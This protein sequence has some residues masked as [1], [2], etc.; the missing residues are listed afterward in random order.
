MW[1]STAA[2]IQ[3]GSTSSTNDPSREQNFQ[4][5]EEDEEEE[6]EELL[7]ESSGRY[8]GEYYESDTSND[9]GTESLTWISWFCSLSGHEYFAEVAED[10][11]E[12]DFNLTGLN[13]T[14][15]FYKEA[16]EMIL[17]VEPEEES[18][19]VPDVSL[20]ENS[21][22]VLYGMIHQR[23]ILTRQ[24]LQQ[25]VDKYENNHFGHCPRVYC[26]PTAVV[27]CGRNDHPGLETVKLFCP[28]CLDLYTPPSSRYHNIDG[29]YFG[30]TFPHL[31]FQQFPELLPNTP[32][33]IY[34]PKI[35]GFKV[36]ERSRSGPRMQ[37]LRMRPNVDSDEDG[38]DVS[39]IEGEN[40][41]GEDDESL[42]DQGGGENNGA[43]ETT[44]QSGV[45]G[46]EI[47]R[48]YKLGHKSNEGGN[49]EM[50]STNIVKQEKPL[51]QKLLVNTRDQAMREEEWA[52][53]SVQDDNFGISPLVTLLPLLASSTV[54]VPT[55]TSINTTDSSAEPPLLSSPSSSSSSSSLR[56]LL[57]TSPETV[58]PESS[59]NQT[60]YT[61]TTNLTQ[62]ENDALN[63][64][65]LSVSGKDHNIMLE[66]R[67][68]M[69][70]ESNKGKRVELLN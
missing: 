43:P 50:L 22:E 21:A 69:M 4:H 8:Q 38:E 27:P 13:S 37:W 30:T 63:T 36:N 32:T 39:D 58:S 59:S 65:S 9:T 31:L 23:Y 68:T 48:T 1:N 61:N 3:A 56:T 11:I 17:D 25:M 49:N 51:T 5:Q 54:D 18:L 35:F 40:D 60:S 33:R 57:E 52:K 6:E 14:V 45:Y 53:E 44:N 70:V 28:N 55:Q 67:S 47:I 26:Q 29:A 41:D 10:F 24:G 42:L 64:V 15:P 34:E 20:V 7:Q 19:K 62:C 46:T 66:E 16:L 2:S 12:D